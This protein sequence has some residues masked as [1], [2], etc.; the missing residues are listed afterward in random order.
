MT[1]DLD[2]EEEPEA[3]QRKTWKNNLR[4]L[5]HPRRELKGLPEAYQKEAQGNAFVIF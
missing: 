1:M 4:S 3:W 2:Q 5:P